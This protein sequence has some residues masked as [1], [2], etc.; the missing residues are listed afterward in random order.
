MLA[1]AP[2][3][4]DLQAAQVET[5][6]ISERG[7]MKHELVRQAPNVPKTIGRL[8]SIHTSAALLDNSAPAVF[9]NLEP[10]SPR[11]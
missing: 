11:P 8:I 9:Q 5:Q 10:L 1:R 6:S 4:A 3:C 2:T 7:H